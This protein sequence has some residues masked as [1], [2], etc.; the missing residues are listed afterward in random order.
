MSLLTL[1]LPRKEYLSSLYPLILLGF[2]FNVASTPGFFDP[3][4]I[5]LIIVVVVVVIVC[6][7]EGTGQNNK[8]AS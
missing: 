2:T 1:F 6:R 8:A 4:V 7:R 3:G 5:I